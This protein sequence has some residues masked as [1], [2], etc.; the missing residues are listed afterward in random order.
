MAVESVSIVLVEM[1]P[2][3]RGLIGKAAISLHGSSTGSALA[4]QNDKPKYLLVT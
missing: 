1:Q 3:K 2:K 4:V